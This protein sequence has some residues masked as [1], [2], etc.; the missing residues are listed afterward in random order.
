MGFPAHVLIMHGDSPLRAVRCQGDETEGRTNDT[1]LI[2]R[3][4]QRIGEE[5]RYA[6]KQ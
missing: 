2:W 3:F 6:K 5:Q 1:D 4:I